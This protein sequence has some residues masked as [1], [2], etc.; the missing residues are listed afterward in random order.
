MQL[1][2]RLHDL[3]SLGLPFEQLLPKVHEEGFT[4]VHLALSKAL[5]GYPCTPS[6]LT[7][8]YA[9]YLKHQFAKNELDV[10]V[11]GNYL[12]LAHPD[13]AEA[14]AIT[15]KY[16]AHLRF[17]SILGC[18]VV[19]TE[20]GSPNRSYAPCPECRTQDALE[21]L[22]RRLAPIVETAEAYGVILAIEPVARHIVCTPER[23]RE[24]LDTIR[25]DNL[26][27]LLDPVNLLDEENVDDHTEILA[28]A[29]ELLGE[30][31]VVVHIKDFVR[32]NGQLISVG[33]GTGEMDYGPL[34]RFLKRDKPFIHATLEDVTPQNAESCRIAIQTA[35]EQL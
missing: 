22:I 28:K 27:I 16:K 10:A 31:V 20:T 15:E 14:A 8:G 19:G 5:S 11:L 1:G 7:P 24:V 17:A 26:K 25:S 6:A 32:R 4:C 35:W 9:M 2:I 33:A 18:G 12:N 29:I 21:L 3:N 23:A 30:D 34:L 13:A